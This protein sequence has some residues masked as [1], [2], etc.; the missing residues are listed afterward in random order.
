M[1]L[2]PS[3]PHKY[4]GAG[5][6]VFE[7]DFAMRL[8]VSRKRPREWSLSCFLVL[9]DILN[10]RMPRPLKLEK[11]AKWFCRHRRTSTFFIARSLSAAECTVVTL[12]DIKFFLSKFWDCWCCSSCNRTTLHTLT[13]WDKDFPPPTEIENPFRG[14]KEISTPNPFSLRQYLALHISI[15]AVEN[16]D[17]IQDWWASSGDTS[18]E[19]R[20]AE[21]ATEYLY[22]IC[23][24][25]AHNPP[26][27]AAECMG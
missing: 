3:S 11:N 7:V 13:T 16:I 22:Y 4:T 18:K 5:G 17:G 14:L 27:D 21:I 12:S 1:A 26:R 10:S 8:G 24:R 25:V 23:K 19:I 20:I 9:R 2:L 6:P 15:E